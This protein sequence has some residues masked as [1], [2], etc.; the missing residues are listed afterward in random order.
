MVERLEQLGKDLEA[1]HSLYVGDV[2]DKQET[3][4]LAECCDE[5]GDAE[6]DDDKFAFQV[7]QGFVVALKP[8]DEAVLVLAKENEQADAFVGRK[9]M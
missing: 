5:D 4:P 9:I 1:H 7:P 2:Y 6:S 8:P 3:P